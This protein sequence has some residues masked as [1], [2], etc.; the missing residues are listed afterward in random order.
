MNKLAKLTAWDIGYVI[1]MSVACLV[2]YSIMTGVLNPI[3]AR[4]DD[5][6]GGMWAAVAA[7]FVFRDTGRASVSAGVARLVATSVSIVLCLIYL[8]LIP[9]TLIA[10]PILLAAGCLIVMLIDRRD[11]IV[12][13]GITTIVVMVVAII[14]PADAW[15]QPLL[16]LVDTVVGIFVGVV[17]NW[18]IVS[19]FKA[20]HSLGAGVEPGRKFPP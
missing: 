18:V 8:I 3:V 7:A 2:S 9:P 19:A 13:T 11:E 20:R 10:L 15:H 5:L 4:D 6:L 14:S 16:R 1:S 17:F 12:T